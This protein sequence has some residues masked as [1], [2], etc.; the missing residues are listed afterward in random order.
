M[1]EYYTL[2]DFKQYWKTT[3]KCVDADFALL[4]TELLVKIFRYLSVADRNAASFTCWQWYEASKYLGFAQ[5][6]CLHLIGIEFDDFKAP[7]M[8][9]LNSSHFFPVIKLTRVKLN[10][11]SKFW[12][13][14]GPFIREI[15]FEKCMIWRERIISVFRHMPNLRMARFVECDLLR[16]DLFKKWK[17]FENGLVNIYFPSVRHLSLAK[18]NFSELQFNVLVDMLPNLTEVDFSS[19]FRN[20]GATRKAQLLNCILTFI[21]HR[22]ND[23]KTLNL[24]GVAVDDLFLRGV[25]ESRGLQLE[26]L[27]FTY[28]EKMPRKEPAIIDL[29]RQ[30]T[31]IGT[32]DLSQST[33]VT[34]FCV[35]QMV[36]YMPDLKLLNLS[37]CCGVSDYGAAQVFKLRQ[38]K[39]L[40][41]SSCRISKRGIFEGMANNNKISLIEL[42]LENLSPLDD[43]CF[44]KIG[45]SFPNLTLLNLAGSASCMTNCALQ[46]VFLH[47]T[48]LK[49]LNLERSTKLTDAGFTGI[50]L[51]QKT[52]AIW[53]IAETFSID[54][55]KKL[56]ILKVSG[57]FKITDFTLRYAFR[58][59]ELK[60]L[61]I[62]RC[63]QISKQGIEKL[64][65]S[66]PALEFLD[67]SECQNIN[68][69]CLELIAMNLKRLS[70]LK[71]S[72]CPLVSEVGLHYLSTY[73]KNLKVC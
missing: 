55:L 52:F 20:I 11:Y 41:L 71:I 56:R 7:V 2:E 69:N 32:L 72:N 73:C 33:G 63:H 6:K 16:D 48:N 10:S 70:T 18:N 57:C 58:F 46:H 50:D 36:K 62:S 12:A 17:F 67:L 35:E 27:S 4:P 66:C 64:V 43:E 68:D 47:L 25:V 3:L 54:R 15:T 13:E 30:Q 1:H 23:L 9:L 39:C 14:F 65:T 38:L 24:A 40:N 51:P 8:D 37:G 44:I 21:Q 49:H 42:H 53:D 5:K 22:Q 60:E 45:L 26:A 59:M 19:C 34:D 28:L 61:S 31:A 29:L